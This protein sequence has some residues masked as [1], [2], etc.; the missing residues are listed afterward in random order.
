MKSLLLIA[1]ALLLAAGTAV[2]NP[3]PTTPQVNGTVGFLDAGLIQAA[4]LDAGGLGVYGSATVGALA[5]VGSLQIGEG[6]NETPKKDTHWVRVLVGK[7]PGTIASAGSLLVYN[8]NSAAGICPAVLT[9]ALA[10]TNTCVCGSSEDQTNGCPDGGTVGSL[11]GLGTADDCDCT[12]PGELFTVDGG[13]ATA[14]NGLTCDC[15]VALDGGVSV[16][17]QN[18][19]G[20]TI[21]A[22]SAAC[23]IPVSI[24]T[25]TH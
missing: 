16:F 3:S 9:N 22:A 23:W 19:S 14:T 24:S 18:E 11:T 10:S 8:V 13:T 1:G 20:G 4:A 17:I 21:C 5:T 7:G 15:S 25:T 12:V 2:V 6:N